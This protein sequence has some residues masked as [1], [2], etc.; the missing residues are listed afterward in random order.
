MAHKSGT[1]KASASVTAGPSSAP[2][3]SVQNSTKVCS[4]CKQPLPNVQQSGARNPAPVRPRSTVTT[5]AA[6]RVMSQRSTARSSNPPRATPIKRQTARSNQG[7]TS[8]VPKAIGGSDQVKVSAIPNIKRECT[9]PSQVTQ[10]KAR[11]NSISGASEGTLVQASEPGSPR[12]T[13]R[14]PPSASASDEH[15]GTPGR[16][17]PIKVE[18]ESLRVPVESEMAMTTTNPFVITTPSGM[19]NLNLNPYR[20]RSV[21][22]RN[23]PWR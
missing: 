9:P 15:P 23:R 2:E 18:E 3:N 7:N 21:H 12:L 10:P 4:S 11:A 8:N 19:N 20:Y 16:R 22:K 14:L 1:T 13:I 6:R 17:T 5:P